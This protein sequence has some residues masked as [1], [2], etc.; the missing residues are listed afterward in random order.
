[1]AG[2]VVVSVTA[3]RE[4][5]G[6]QPVMTDS[7]SAAVPRHF[8]KVKFFNERGGWGFLLSPKIEGDVFV[9]RKELPEGLDM[10]TMHQTVTFELHETPDG[11]RAKKVQLSP[12]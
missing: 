8:G 4:Q 9:H 10:L 5:A 7:A 6:A 3:D 2:V 1:M 12:V 11:R